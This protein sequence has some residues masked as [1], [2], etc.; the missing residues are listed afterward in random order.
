MPEGVRLT[1]E[2]LQ[3]DSQMIMLGENGYFKIR[4]LMPGAYL[5]Y[6]AIKGYSAPDKPYFEVLAKH[7]VTN[8]VLQ[9]QPDEV[10]H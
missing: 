6:P 9:L 2:P 8:L 3:G 5:I 1:L 10:V 7:D 4:G